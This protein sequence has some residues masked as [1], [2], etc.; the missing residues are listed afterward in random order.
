MEVQVRQ[1]RISVWKEYAKVG[2]R[3]TAKAVLF[4]GA[5]VC[6]YKALLFANAGQDAAAALMGALFVVLILMTFLPEMETFKAFGVEM[7]LRARLTEAE[8][9]LKKLRALTVLNAN[10]AYHLLTY[11]NRW[12]SSVRE[13][14]RTA[15]AIDAFMRDMNCDAEEI[16]R[17]KAAFVTMGLRDLFVRHYN[18]VVHLM[19]QARIAAAP[20]A[21]GEIDS[22]LKLRATLPFN[23]NDFRAS[24]AAMEPPATLLPKADEEFLKVLAS[25]LTKEADELRQK[26]VLSEAGIDVLAS[27]T[28]D[29]E[30]V[31]W[32]K[33]W[34]SE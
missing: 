10:T 19:Q 2:L 8:D 34:C 29:A 16:R 31:A 20:P 27:V 7:K 30:Y 33:K 12:D 25:K 32:L 5:L 9:L 21:Q 17:A 15:R 18:A 14:Y 13:T 11:G 23:E 26:G 6:F 4:A 24:C 28:G 3:W 1:E 22:F